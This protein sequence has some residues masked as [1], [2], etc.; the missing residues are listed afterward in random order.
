MAYID[1]NNTEFSIAVLIKEAALNQSLL[2]QHYLEP[3]QQRGV[4]TD[5][6]VAISLDYDGK[7]PSAKCRKAYLDVLLP[8]IEDMG[9]N[10]LM[11]CDGEY[12]KSLTKEK[13]AEPWLGDVLPCKIKG[14]EHINVLY[15]CNYQSY[16]VNPDNKAKSELAFKALE[17]YLEGTYRPLGTN[18][19]KQVSYPSTVA[20]IEAALLALSAEPA[21]TVDIEAYDLKH[22]NA[23]IGSISFSIDEHTSVAFL[24]DTEAIEPVKIDVWDKKDKKFKKRTAHNKQGF[25]APVR[26]LLKQFFEE[27]R[28]SCIYHNASY[29]VYV[30]VYQLFMADLLDSKGMQR[31]LEVML[32]GFEDTQLITYLATNNCVQNRL[33]LKE[34]SH[35]FT[36]NYAIEVNDIRLQPVDRLLEYNAI[37]TCATWFVMNKHYHTMV[38]DDQL[39]FYQTIFKTHIHDI[40]EMQLTGLCLDP[41]RVE[42]VFSELTAIRD[43][44]QSTLL[45]NPYVTTFVDQEITAEVISRNAE[46]KT[47]IIDASEAKFAFNPNSG[48]Q[49]QRLLYECMQLPVIDTTQTK[50]PATGGDTLK[51]LSRHLAVTEHDHSAQIL[52][53]L[54]ELR[55]YADCS[56]ILSTF[57]RAFQH[58]SITCPDGSTR[59]FGNFRMGGT[60]SGRLSSNSPNMQ[61]LPSGSRFGKL[62]KSCFIAPPNHLF[63]MSDYAALEDVVNTLLTKDPAKQKVMIDGFDGH[64]YRA[65]HFWPELFTDYDIE[66][67]EDVNWLKTQDWSDKIRSRGKPVHFSQQYLGG[68]MTLHLNS[69]FPKEEAQE[70]SNRYREL[71]KV[72]F[73]WVNDRLEEAA[74]TGYAT[75]A[76]GL[77][78]RAPVLHQCLLN[79]QHTPKEAAAESRTL[80]NAISGQSY[81]LLNGRASEEFMRRV[82]TSKYRYSIH[83]CA[84]IHDAIY[85]YIKDDIGCLKWVNDNLIDC[86]AWCDLPE[87]YHPSLRVSSQL[88]I[89]Y[90]TWADAFTLPTDATEQ[91]LID[92]IVSER[93]KRQ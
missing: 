6:L 49:I 59:I 7:K 63:V 65:C 47:K 77:R 22:Y 45:S 75:G 58:D 35:E 19:L 14:Y 43:H 27:Y 54:G 84:H 37:D 39:E 33:G 11:C 57:I 90:P 3:L 40:I 60:V 13:K 79:N 17:S 81:C 24:V 55:N 83:L 72:S 56:K 1:F 61:N 34:Q 18:V 32:R 21:V 10:V 92:C 44:A 23:G 42:A 9:I 80:G 74:Q 51:K 48:P 69:G 8:Q 16:F 88:D 82:R 68:W 30:L 89:A 71:Y 31:G 76:F 46:Y 28:G 91:Q 52:E 64:M 36:G 86:M 29:D 87:L 78:I 67:K 50:Q 5:T 2:V 66:S 15:C 20:D 41:V 25:N 12:F 73:D 70:I 62:I 53:V 26:M 85:L 4:A 93:D 38:L